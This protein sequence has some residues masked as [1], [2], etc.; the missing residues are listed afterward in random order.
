M[1]LWRSGHRTENVGLPFKVLCRVEIQ[2]PA[3]LADQREDLKAAVG[4]RYKEH[5]GLNEVPP[6]TPA[7]CAHGVASDPA[8]AFQQPKNTFAGFALLVGHWPSIRGSGRDLRR[9]GFYRD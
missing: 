1:L 6:S 2:V 9:V 4:R 3:V 7:R 8:Q 5:R